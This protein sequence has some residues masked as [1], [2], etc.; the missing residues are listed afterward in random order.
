M[1]KKSLLFLG[2]LTASALFL[3]CPGP[4]E[5]ADA[6]SL[7]LTTPQAYLAPGLT[8]T[9]TATVKP[10]GFPVTFSSDNM[11]VASVS[12][13][14]VVS[15]VSEGT[16]T[17]TAA[18]GTKKASATVTVV[19]YTSVSIA[20]LPEDDYTIP[21]TTSK[22]LT[23][24]WEPSGVSVAPEIIKWVSS[25]PDAF[26]VDK[27]GLVTSNSDTESAEIH[28]EIYD[29]LMK[30]KAVTVSGDEAPPVPAPVV[31]NLRAFTGDARYTIYWDAVENATE[32]KLYCTTD[33]AKPAEATATLTETSHHVTSATNG[34]TINIWVEAVV[35][36]T[37]QINDPAHTTVTVG[38]NG[39]SNASITVDSQTYTLDREVDFREGTF[40]QKW[41]TSTI[42]YSV[43]SETGILTQK[44][45]S[46]SSGS[47][48]ME[49]AD[50][51]GANSRLIWTPPADVLPISEYSY[52]EVELKTSQPSGTP[53]FWVVLNHNNIISYELVH[54]N[55]NNPN[56]WFLS[57]GGEWRSN[58]KTQKFH[59]GSG[60]SLPSQ[61]DIHKFGIL[62]P[63]KTPS[64]IRIYSDRTTAYVNKDSF[65]GGNAA[66]APQSWTE[67]IPT[68]FEFIFGAA[69]CP[70]YTAEISKIR[71][72][73]AS[74]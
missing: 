52:I 3:G 1:K 22:Q 60:I 34:E 72:Y 11:G 56:G 16:A 58:G 54:Y 41:P 67:N 59:A 6:T 69:D 28:A 17:V 68:Y 23:L 27:N 65:D 73:K 55:N 62:F 24:K 50:G 35:A 18:A 36:G 71:Y 45:G 13:K 40:E 10:E 63:D 64:K 12:N 14:G 5:S 19:P 47:S 26:P 29:G 46:G 4:E 33:T 51:A 49:E 7:T 8:M 74:N 48:Y 30:T 42:L 61:G 39:N 57:Y 44:G 32:Y 15:G 20:P 37:V 9:V 31:E 21:N 66:S 70:N 53:G 38:Y 43:D 2:V 25:N